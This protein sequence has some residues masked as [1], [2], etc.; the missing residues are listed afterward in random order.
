ML[1]TDLVMPDQE[2]IETIRLARKAFP[3]LRII[4][5]SGAFFGQFLKMAE[6]LGANAVLPKPL[7]QAAMLDT[8]R[9]VLSRPPE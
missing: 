6:L 4:A 2:G 5:I 3:Q 7:S 9:D 8:I 1:I